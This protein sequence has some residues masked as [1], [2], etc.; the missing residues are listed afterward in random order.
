M[1]LIFCFLVRNILLKNLHQCHHTMINFFF[2]SKGHDF[3]LKNEAQNWLVAVVF[4]WRACNFTHTPYPPSQIS[5]PYMIAG[6]NMNSENKV[7]GRKVD[8]SS[9]STNDQTAESWT[10]WWAFFLSFFL[11]LILSWEQ[12]KHAQKWR[13]QYNKLSC[14][15][16]PI[17]KNH[18]NKVDLIYS[19][20][21]LQ[22]PF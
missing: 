22:S 3:Y 5:V 11:F 6:P 20:N 4:S 12:F 18:Q 19:I 17:F 21:L 15:H 8:S 13:Q 1:N 10:V 14:A 9:E 7:A 2:S 16:N